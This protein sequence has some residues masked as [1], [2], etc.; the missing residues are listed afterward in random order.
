MNTAVCILEYIFHSF[1]IILFFPKKESVKVLYPSQVSTILIKIYHTVQ[2]QNTTTCNLA[3]I[4]NL[5]YY[6]NAFKETLC[7][8]KQETTTFGTLANGGVARSTA[9]AST[10]DNGH[11]QVRNGNSGNSSRPPSRLLATPTNTA[12]IQLNGSNC[13]LL[14]VGNLRHHPRKGSAASTADIEPI[15]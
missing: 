14:N 8:K 7:G 4:L 11:L 5:T 13:N 2:I 6:R 15:R 3:K 1:F 10:Y 9:A 12:A